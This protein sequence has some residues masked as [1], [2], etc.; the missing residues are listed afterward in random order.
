M[1]NK[2]QL[3]IVPPMSQALQKLNEILE[4][5]ASDEN[6]DISLIDDL[7]ELGQVLSNSGQCLILCSNPKKCATFLQE[8]RF[9]ISRFHSKFS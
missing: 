6:I 9:V 3:I 1:E 2:K 8:N 4:G 7:K 5:I